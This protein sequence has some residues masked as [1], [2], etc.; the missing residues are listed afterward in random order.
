MDYPQAYES[1][2]TRADFYNKVFAL[3]GLSILGTGL[4]IFVGFNF[5]MNAFF[6][7]PGLAFL[8]WGG[9]LVLIMT[10]GAWSQKTPLN[11]GLFTLFTVLSGLSVVPLL[12]YYIHEFQGF[13]ILYRALFATTVM[14]LGMGLIGHSIQKPLNGLVGFLSMALLALI[15]VSLMGIFFPWG[16]VMEF[17]FSLAGVFIFGIWA[18]VD[19]NRLKQ[20]P[21]EAYI[22]AAMALYLDF[23]N[24]F[25]FILR[26]MSRLSRD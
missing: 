7:V 13:D 14:F 9:E 6:T 8:F 26:L 4:G 20:Y 18:L 3:F 23:F 1:S 17:Y 16:E 15:I 22:P 5:L 10:S 24:L 11:Y 19:V 12:A 25:L 21:E 2:P